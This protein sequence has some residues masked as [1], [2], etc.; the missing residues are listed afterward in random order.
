MISY[1]DEERL[2]G[3]TISRRRT[4]SAGP[5]LTD[6]FS[7]PVPYTEQSFKEVTAILN[8]LLEF[9]ENGIK[10]VIFRLVKRSLYLCSI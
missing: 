4:V 2:E 6:A 1:K 8:G 7:P 9:R 5:S 3:S 10:N